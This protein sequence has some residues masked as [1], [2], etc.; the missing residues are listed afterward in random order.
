[1]TYRMAAVVERDT[2]PSLTP[3]GRELAGR[4]AAGAADLP[5]LRPSDRPG[6]AVLR[7]LR[8]PA[9]A[10]GVAAAP[11]VPDLR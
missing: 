6:G 3:R 11:A 9:G 8:Q 4:A 5:G 1:M 10:D 7:G 2:A